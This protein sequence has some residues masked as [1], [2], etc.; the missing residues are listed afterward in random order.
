V[1]LRDSGRQRLTFTA[2]ERLLRRE[3]AIRDRLLEAAVVLRL[4]SRLVGGRGRLLVRGRLR[5]TL[6][7]ANLLDGQDAQDD[8]IGCR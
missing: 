8:R 1:S 5:W 6:N 3:T 4:A 2:L 7:V